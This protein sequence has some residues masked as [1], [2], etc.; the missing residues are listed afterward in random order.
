MYELYIK[1]RDGRELKTKMSE[2]KLR[3][4]FTKLKKG[5][6][7]IRPFKWATITTPSGVKKDMT[8][9]FSEFVK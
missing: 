9:Q 8:S 5:K 3:E 6:E 2:S 7:K 4:F 1:F